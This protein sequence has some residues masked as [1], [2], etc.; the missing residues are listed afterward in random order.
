MSDKWNTIM[1]EMAET[2]KGAKDYAEGMLAA[3]KDPKRVVAY[4]HFI[5]KRMQQDLEIADYTIVCAILC[6]SAL[7]STAITCLTERAL[8]EAGGDKDGTT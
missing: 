7:E 2:A 6:S 5:S 4:T 1:T 3:N 8:E